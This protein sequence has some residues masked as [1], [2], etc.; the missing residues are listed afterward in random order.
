VADRIV[1]SQLVDDGSA[2][3]ASASSSVKS[4]ASAKQRYTLPN[5]DDEEEDW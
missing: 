4:S 3:S 1:P 2:S 5:L